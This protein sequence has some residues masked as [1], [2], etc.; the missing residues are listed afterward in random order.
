MARQV[1]VIARSLSK[2]VEKDGCAP[3]LGWQMVAA[4]S[5]AECVCIYLI[6]V[7]IDELQFV[8]FEVCLHTLT[9]TLVASTTY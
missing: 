5:V 9:P 3:F 1:G 8:N 6:Q 2:V 7:V 4:C